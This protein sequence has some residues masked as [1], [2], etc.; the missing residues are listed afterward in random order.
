MNDSQRLA[1][2]LSANLSIALFAVSMA[3]LAATSGAIVSFADRTQ[4]P[5]RVF[6]VTGGGGAILAF[7]VSIC[8]GGK[9]VAACRRTAQRDPNTLPDDYDDG[10][11][12]RQVLSGL[13]GILLGLF[14]FLPLAF[15][16]EDKR[17]SV[18]SGSVT[19]VI[20]SSG[21]GARSIPSR[22]LED[23]PIATSTAATADEFSGDS[24]LRRIDV[25]PRAK[26]LQVDYR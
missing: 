12:S 20:F 18:P 24:R 26:S 7:L 23:P 8:F 25:V 21:D 15:F 4:G 2:Q 19:I 11:F 3:L 14:A 10:F 17:C 1:I 13:I 9:G 22:W 5:G 6:F 16:S